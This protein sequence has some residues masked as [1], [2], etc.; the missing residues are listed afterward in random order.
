MSEVFHTIVLAFHI[1]GAG[2]IIGGLL[3]SLLILIKPKISPE[4]LS[5][6]AILGKFISMAIGV[7]ILS[8]IYL[9][10]VEW[11]E[12]RSSPLLFLKIILLVVDGL[13][14]GKVVFDRIKAGD[15]SKKHL[16]WF[17]LAVFILITTLGVFLAES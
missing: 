2:I 8:G 14:G 16:I 5:H 13:F 9:A 17:A 15:A 1:L 11:D 12:F 3:A 7:Q 4:F 10:A 6:L